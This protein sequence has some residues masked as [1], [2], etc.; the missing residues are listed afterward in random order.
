MPGQDEMF[1][2]SKVESTDELRR[3]AVSAWRALCYARKRAAGLDNLP[4]LPK[5]A[6]AQAEAR[7]GRFKRGGGR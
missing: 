1:P 3:L 7:W 6:L 5:G 2:A 4:P